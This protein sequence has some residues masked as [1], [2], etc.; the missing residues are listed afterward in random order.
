MSVDK[1]Q[2]G[3]CTLYRGDCLEVLPTLD[4]VDIVIADPPYGCNKAT[5]DADFFGAWYPLAKQISRA[6]VLITG[7][8]GLRDSLALVGGDV[9]DII[10]ARNMNGM[11]RGPLGF[12]NWLA[13]VYCGEKPRMG[14]NAFDFTVSG[15]K[16]DHPSPKPERYMVKLVER[17]SIQG[18]SVL[19][20]C[21]GSGTTGVACVKTGRKFIGIELDPGYFDIAC[22]RIEKAY[23][24]APLLQGGAA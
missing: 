23:A 9:V 1:V 14:P 13:A 19:D 6:Q 7:S 22:R 15:D 10:A 11:T 21:M 3:E 12:G 17:V 20:P 2:I 18:D 5:W 8:I 16:P 24:D 4:A